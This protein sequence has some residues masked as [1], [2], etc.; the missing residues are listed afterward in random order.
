M[1]ALER[2][3]SPRMCRLRCVHVSDSGGD[4]TKLES[5]VE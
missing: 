1:S 2:R 5:G 3:I 4:F